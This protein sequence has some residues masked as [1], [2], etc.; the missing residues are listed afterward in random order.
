M[1]CKILIID[2]ATS[3]QVEL[4]AAADKVHP[5]RLHRHVPLASALAKAYQEKSSDPEFEFGKGLGTGARLR[6]LAAATFT[7]LW[8]ATD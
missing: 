5:R 7:S 2:F 3:A 1:L 6:A 4:A 8:P